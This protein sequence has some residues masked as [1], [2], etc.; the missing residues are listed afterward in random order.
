VWSQ[1]VTVCKPRERTVT[2]WRRAEEA[3][4]EGL[5][6]VSEAPLALAAVGDELGHAFEPVSRVRVVVRRRWRGR[7]RVRVHGA[8]VTW[9]SHCHQSKSSE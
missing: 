9:Q 2:L 5:L 7:G 1:I 3:V 4:E 6:V 8:A